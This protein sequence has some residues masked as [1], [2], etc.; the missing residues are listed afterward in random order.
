MKKFLAILGSALMGLMFATGVYAAPENVV[1][2]VTFADLLVVAE[3]TPLKFGVLDEALNTGETVIISPDAPPTVTDAGS[4]ILG[5]TQAAADI[6]ITA[7]T[8]VALSIQ[9]S[10][11][12]DG[13]GYALSA[14][15][16]SYNDLANTACQAAPYT[17]TSIASATL[18]IGATLTGDNL[19]VPG[20][21]NGTFDVTIIYQ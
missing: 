19:A 3:Q 16:C 5:G 7:T 17:P 6:T 4:N 11:I 15:M 2:E 13:T 8:G 18:L 1:A 14:F 10:N 20:A 12:V 21:A 9:V